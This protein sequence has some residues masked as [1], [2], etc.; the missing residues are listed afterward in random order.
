[1]QT[2][3]AMPH[4]STRIWLLLGASLTA[5]T[6]GAVML[7]AYSLTWRSVLNFDL[8]SQDWMILWHI[9]LPRVLLAGVVGAALAVSG[10]AL[11]GLFRNPLAD[12]G[13]IGISSG[14]A[15]AAALVIVLFPF[16]TGWMGLYG[17]SVAAFLGGA[18]TCWLIFK[19]G[20]L[21]AASSVAHLIL[22][23]I[24]VN[25]LCGAAVGFLTYLSTYEQ[26]R[27][28]TFW[29]MGS[30]GGALWPSVG[31]SFTITLPV[32]GMLMRQSSDL[33]RLLLGEQEARY[34]GTDT[35][36]L[37]TRVITL[38]AIAVGAA[39]AVS[40]IVGF[41]GLVAPH[42]VRLLWKADHRVLIPASAVLGA[43]LTISADTLARTLFAPAEMPVGIL[44]SLIG[45]PFFLWLLLSR[46]SGVRS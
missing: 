40:G 29:T 44:T 31:V 26:L 19:V 38:S 7:G 24:A 35:E 46:K 3:S 32:I 5:A 2:L 45:G 27:T 18:A 23:G 25:A 1:M 9:R 30:F 42:L 15:L 12:P 17:L 4:K 14:S 10:A 8:S 39:V 34:L 41:V 20:Q 33:N 22:A 11:Q 13:L 37:K 28:L 16:S 43:A 21:G 6:L 36:K